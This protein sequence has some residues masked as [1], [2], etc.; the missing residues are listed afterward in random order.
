M[1]IEAKVRNVVTT[2]KIYCVKDFPPQILAR[3][4]VADVANAL[5]VRSIRLCK[6]Y[7]VVRRTC[8]IF[9]VCAAKCDHSQIFG[10]Q[11]EEFGHRQ[12]KATIQF[13]VSVSRK[14]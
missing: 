3:P 12:R 8:G 11:S 9:I 10:L 13:G 14:P 1:W 2:R 4:H 7:N 6:F 5:E